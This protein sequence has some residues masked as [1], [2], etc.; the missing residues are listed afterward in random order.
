MENKQLQVKLICVRSSN[1][2]NITTATKLSTYVYL[3]IYN[4]IRNCIQTYIHIYFYNY[5]LFLVN[6]KQRHLYSFIFTI[7][8]RRK[9]SF[10]CSFIYH[11]NLCHKYRQLLYLGRTIGAFLTKKFKLQAFENILNCKYN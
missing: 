6:Q 5:N 1:Y 8:L 3:I 7:S 4:Y 11:Y 10:L 9:L 2:Y